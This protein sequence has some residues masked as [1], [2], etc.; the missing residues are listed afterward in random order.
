MTF[1]IALLVIQLEISKGDYS[2]AMDVLEKAATRSKE[3]DVDISQNIKLMNM[4]AHIYE[5]AG[6]PLKG[7]SVALRAAILAH[8]SKILPCLWE[9]VSALC[10][11]LHSVQDYDSSAKLLDSILPQILEG[12]ACDSIAQAFSLLADAHM[13]MASEAKK[14]MIRRQEHLTKASENLGKAFD[15]FSRVEDVKRQCEMLAKQATIMHLNGDAMLAN[16]GAARYLSIQR[17]AADKKW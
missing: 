15:A 13:G 8:R 11:I 10:A 4:K 16:D 5:R 9:A 6:L 14:E 17:A 12:E 3:E 7:F 2:K 1:N